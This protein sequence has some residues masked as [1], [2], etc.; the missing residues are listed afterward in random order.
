MDRNYVYVYS[1]CGI[2]TVKDELKIIEQAE[3][4]N[5][6]DIFG[7]MAKYV[8]GGLTKGIL[9][10]TAVENGVFLNGLKKIK[11]LLDFWDRS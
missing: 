8:L 5:I 11:K 6:G 3:F 1:R 9:W 4:E 7:V 10:S 2:K